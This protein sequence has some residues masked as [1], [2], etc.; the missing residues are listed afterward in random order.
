G[1]SFAAWV[2]RTRTGAFERAHRAVF[3]VSRRGKHSGGELFYS[4]AVFS[5][6]PAPDERWSGPARD[7]Q[8]ADRFH[9]EADAASSEI[10]FHSGGFHQRRVSRGGSRCRETG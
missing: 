2:R 8:A 3:A 9:A 1:A 5:L 7:P 6:T 10:R 4:R